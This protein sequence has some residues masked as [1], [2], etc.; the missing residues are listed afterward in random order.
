MSSR[1][2]FDAFGRRQYQNNDYSYD[3]TIGETY[4][5]HRRSRYDGN[6]NREYQK[7]EN[8]RDKE[9]ENYIARLQANIESKRKEIKEKDTLLAAKEGQIKSLT[10]YYKVKES[11]GVKSAKEIDADITSLKE[12]LRLKDED[13]IEWN[14]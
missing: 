6:R 3:A 9:R 7:V 13:I 12:Q 11:T 8:N 2:K 1:E 14:N 4:Q 5:Y 10:K